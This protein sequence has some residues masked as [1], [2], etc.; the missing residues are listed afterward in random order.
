ME[1]LY[2]DTAGV[3]PEKDQGK[4]GVT[5]CRYSW[6]SPRGR[7]G[8]KWS[9]SVQI[10]LDL[11]QRKTREK[12]ESLFDRYCWSSPRGRLGRRWSHSVQI[13]LDLSQ[14]KTREKMESLCDRYCWISPRGRPGRRW[15]HSVTDIVGSLPEKDQGEDGVTL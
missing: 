11:S 9:H 8:R 5:L 10:L 15:S 3:L 12:M 13:L 1:S 6:S 7:P 4:D 2:A 14:R